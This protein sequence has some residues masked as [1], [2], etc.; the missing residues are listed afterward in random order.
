MRPTPE[1]VVRNVAFP[2]P[3]SDPACALGLSDT[4]DDTGLDSTQ[5]AVLIKLL[6]TIFN[7]DHAAAAKW[8]G[9]YCEAGEVRGKPLEV[10]KA[11]HVERVMRFLRSAV[12]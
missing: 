5:T 11:G 12:P 6:L 2:M 7:D 10:L 1:V 4:L 8:L 9:Q 3:K